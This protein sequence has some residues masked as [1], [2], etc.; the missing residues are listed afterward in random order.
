MHYIRV[1]IGTAILLKLVKGICQAT[2]TTAYLM[3][4]YNGKCKANCAFCPQARNS[5]GRSD[6]LSR[7]LWPKFKLS[8][9]IDALNSKT[10][11]RICVQALNYNGFVR[12]ISRIV[13]SLSSIGIPIS[14]S[15]PPVS[16]NVLKEFKSIGV[17]RIGISFDAVNP[18]IF[19]EIKGETYSWNQHVKFLDNALKVFGKGNVTVHIIIGLGENEYET[20][21]FVN[22]V[23]N[24]GAL[25]GLF[26]FTPIQGTRLEH[27]AKPS[28]E[29]Y[30]RLQL[31]T[32]L[33]EKEII[34]LEDIEFNSK[35]EVLRINIEKDKLLKIIDSGLPF[36]TRGCPDCNRPYYNEE[37]TGPYYNYPLK[38]GKNEIEKIKA[39]DLHNLLS[40][41]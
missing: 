24:K 33:L 29:K 38:P 26:A 36:I 28:V 31:S 18:E 11:K 20:I 41:M 4:Y 19:S 7:V 30:R 23:I 34:K 40:Y 35:S 16:I 25:I 2:P 21:K 1:S 12:D 9:V 5:K 17:E 15:T 13:N 10:V 32:Y 14:L 39:I 6:M 8:D 22:E 3:T 27:V 37:P